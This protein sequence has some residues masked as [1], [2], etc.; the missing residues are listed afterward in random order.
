LDID[1]CN[2]PTDSRVSGSSYTN[3]DKINVKQK[4]IG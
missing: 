1:G 2:N 3:D 4:L